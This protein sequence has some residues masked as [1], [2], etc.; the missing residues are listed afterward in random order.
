MPSDNNNTDYSNNSEYYKNESTKNI[1][2]QFKGVSYFSTKQDCEISDKNKDNSTQAKKKTPQT[3][4]RAVPK[5]NS[6]SDIHTNSFTDKNLSRVQHHVN[7]NYYTQSKNLNRY[8][9]L[10]PPITMKTNKVENKTNLRNSN[11]YLEPSIFKA[12]EKDSSINCVSSISS[13]IDFDFV[14]E[15]EYKFSG[16]SEYIVYTIYENQRR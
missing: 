5:N 15:K 14:D 8:N 11:E 3:V 9:S 7:N 12:T 4:R 10:P 2:N 6:H 1:H 16:N 13:D